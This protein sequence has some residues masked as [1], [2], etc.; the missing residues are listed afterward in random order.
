VC[1]SVRRTLAGIGMTIARGVKGKFSAERL[2]APQSVVLVGAT[3]IEGGRVL[4]NLRGGGFHGNI[5][6][7]GEGPDDN[8]VK[9]VPSIAALPEAPDL[10]VLACKSAEAGDA[11]HALAKRGTRA[12]VAVSEIT[13]LAALGV[14]AGV[15]VLGPHSFGIAAPKLGL[16]AT[17]A[18]MPVPA[19]RVAMVT[20]SAGLARAVLDWAGPNGVGFSHVIGVGANADLG[21]ALALDWLSRDPD[22]GL[23][24]LDIRRVRQGRGFISAARA[25]S[26]LRPVVAIRPGGRL[27]DPTGEGEAV[28]A[29]ALQRAGVFVV[30]TLEALFAAAET[31]SRAKKLRG[32]A[33][34]VVTNAIGPGRLA[35]DAALAAGIKLAILPAE[36]QSALAASLPSELVYGLVYAGSAAPTHVAEIAAML[37]AVP[38]VGGVLVL[39][40]PTGEGDAAAVEAVVA[41]AASGPLPVLACVMGETSGAAHRRRL[42]EAGLPVFATPEQAVQAFGHLLRDRWARIAA[43]ELPGR[44][45]LE[46]APDH[47]AVGASI[48]AARA[49]RRLAMS[50]AEG[51][52]V[53]AAYGITIGPRMGDATAA[54]VR[55]RDDPTFGPVIAVRVGVRGE[56][57]YELPPLNLPLA[58]RFAA[59]AGLEGAAA[60]AMA[61]LLVRVS[62]LLVDEGVL[63]SVR[64]DPLWVGEASV[65]CET[66]VIE[67]RPPGEHA[68]LAISP[69][70]EHLVE[71][72]AARGEDFV[73]RPIR[74]EDAQAHA[75]FMSR[76]PPEDLRY[77]FFT[78][79]REISPEQM[80]RLTQIDYDREM[81][82]LAVRARDKA[83][84][85]VARLVREMGEARGEFAIVVEPS[86]KGFGLAS[87][88]MQR[89]IDWA[90]DVGVREVAGTVLAD[91]HPMLAFVKHL[92]FEV[93]RVPDEA[94]VVEAV[95]AL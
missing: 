59:R 61:R 50:A 11:L 1:Y 91:N 21:F 47:A 85:G 77:R 95:L 6:A 18:H 16:N 67:L 70:P 34:A 17:L 87:H 55:V 86:V 42:A 7:I 58:E 56:I 73:I 63:A 48:L 37:S 22:T 81:A 20:Q 35:A 41:A 69:Y 36:A 4:A 43:R 53:L 24:I 66:A 62:Q 32:E 26:R 23:I 10:A 74:P 52:A 65:R 14:R 90:R 33:L 30:R 9:F 27:L 49:E 28:F 75:A 60:A 78:A 72:Y 39:L 94:D 57:Q 79:L 40:T 13:E 64:L 2:Y 12:A 92:G 76:V 83:T 25:A 5:Y 54:V 44:R 88:L 29:A 19:G 3:S 45:V 71:N 31:L 68:E 93:H 89:L 38:E 46:V 51:A 82:F 8:A 84:V 80:A 15:R